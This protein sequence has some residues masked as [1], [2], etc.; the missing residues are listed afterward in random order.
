MF[1]NVRADSNFRNDTIRSLDWAT[2]IRKVTND[3][4]GGLKANQNNNAAELQAAQDEI[5]ELKARLAKYEKPAAEPAD[6]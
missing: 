2:L 5:E 6:E 1:V 3:A 4:G